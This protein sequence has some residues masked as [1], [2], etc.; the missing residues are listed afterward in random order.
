[1]RFGGAW[2]LHAG[3]AAGIVP[4]C[5]AEV[6]GPNAGSATDLKQVIS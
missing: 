4:S 1:M 5:R 3:G 2:A 6:P